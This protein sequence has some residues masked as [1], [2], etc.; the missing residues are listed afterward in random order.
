MSR[1]GTVAQRIADKG[2]IGVTDA[3]YSRKV[4]DGDASGRRQS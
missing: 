4:S 1:W 2:N 3:V